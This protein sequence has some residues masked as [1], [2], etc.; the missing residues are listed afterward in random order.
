MT[1]LAAV[2]DPC[3]DDCLECWL[4]TRLDVGECRGT[5][6]LVEDWARSRA[7]DSDSLIDFLASRGGYC[8]CEVLLNVLLD[9][10]LVL[11]DLVV[12]CGS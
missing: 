10:R 11:D 3:L 5:T 2:P 9:G 4:Q 12:S 1:S 8:D 7:A 6:D